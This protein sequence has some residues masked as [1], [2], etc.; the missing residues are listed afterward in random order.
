MGPCD[1]TGYYIN[2]IYIYLLRI[3]F[4]NDYMKRVMSYSKCIIA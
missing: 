1:A 2:N 3:F 4:S